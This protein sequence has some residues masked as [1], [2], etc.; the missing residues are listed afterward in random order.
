MSEPTTS[1]ASVVVVTGANGLVGA[2]SASCWSSGERLCGPSYAVRA[3][4]PTSRGSRSGSASSHDPDFAAAVVAGADAV[5]TTVHPMGADR[6]TQQR[7]AVEGTSALARAAATPE[8]SASCM[9]PPPRSMRTAQSGD[10]DESSPL[11]PDDAND[12]AVTKRDTDLS[13]AEIDG[14]TR[15]PSDRRRS[16]VPESLGVENTLRPAR[17]SATTRS[18]D[19]PSPTRPS[20][21]STST[22]S[23]ASAST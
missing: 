11:V 5:I 10:Q 12:Y 7:I 19:T 15:V 21:G 22:T 23:R 17:R 14:I 4:P 20:A 2:G 6:E 16:W 8:S 1:P 3:R 13:L 18:R 9:S